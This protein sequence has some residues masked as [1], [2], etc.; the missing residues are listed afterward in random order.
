MLIAG[1]GHSMERPSLLA[2]AL[3]TIA[4]TASSTALRQAETQGG[5]AT[6][7]EHGVVG[8]NATISRPLGSTAANVSGGAGEP[9]PVP[10]S[11]IGDLAGVIRTYR[12]PGALSTDFVD[13]VCHAGPVTRIA[14]TPDEK[15]VITGASDGSVAVLVFPVDTKAKVAA[16]MSSSSPLAAS[17]AT[18]V[19]VSDERLPWAEE[20][21]VREI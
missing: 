9:A 21:L 11:P 2:T 4:A 20:I 1:L 8:M 19:G 7:L 18:A 10:G 16:A 15:L 13:L 14:V 6:S 5:N 17:G 12:T 3:P